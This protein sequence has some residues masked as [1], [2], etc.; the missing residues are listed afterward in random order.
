[1]PAEGRDV[2]AELDTF[3]KLLAHN[4]TTHPG[5]I[6]LREKDF[7]IWQAFTWAQY[8]DWVEKRALGL[9]LLG[10]RRGDVV[11]LIG[12]NRPGWVVGEIAAHA[13]G[14]L[15]IGLYRDA[16]EDEVA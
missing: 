6:A 5:A 3:P 4:A 12:D 2:T 8:Q 11:A 16:L 14:A 7:G 1:M 13:V 10:V 9:H 15:S